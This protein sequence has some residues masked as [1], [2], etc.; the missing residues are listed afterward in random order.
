MLI[1]RLESGFL[2]FETPEG[3]VRAELSFRQRLQLLWTFRHFRQ[4]SI[5]LLNERERALVN[6]LFQHNAGVVAPS[7]HTSPVIGIIE[8]FVPPPPQTEA[9]AE[10]PSES[11]PVLEPVQQE[12]VEER[13]PVAETSDHQAL[14]TARTTAAEEA[15]RVDLSCAAPQGAIAF[16]EP[17]IS[18]KRYP[19][20][21]RLFSAAC[22]V[23][24]QKLVRRPL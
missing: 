14:A 11:F 15:T 12:Q 1:E 21:N 4:L 8:N 2:V 7:D 18:L 9:H 24:L 5:P 3:L 16:A 17:A 22:R 19:D 10:L 6:V 23:T 13:T 20:T